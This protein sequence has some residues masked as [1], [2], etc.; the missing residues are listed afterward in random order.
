MSPSDVP[1]G[2][3]P[4]N[5]VLEVIRRRRSIRAY[6]DRQ[7]PE[8]ALEAVLEAARW[9]PSAVNSQPWQF[10][11][12]TDPDRRRLLGEIARFYFLRYRHVGS[13]PAIIAVLGRPTA[14]RW[15]QIDC[16]LAA[17]NIM[18][19]AESLG[20]G[21]CYVG[22]FSVPA[23][24]RILGVSPA[25][26]VVGLITLGYPAERPEPPPRLGLD[27]FVHRE[28]YNPRRAP[29]LS[30]RLGRSGLFSLRKRLRA[31]LSPRRRS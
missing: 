30:R 23:A 9:A 18:L 10:V 2:P 25:L 29:T 11:V 17:A 24:R 21:T 6:L 16:A 31:W 19:A 20:L 12:V 7:V 5:P 27:E 15:Y 26:D 4:V 14:N 3:A 1:T 13:A 22:G 8:E 28:V